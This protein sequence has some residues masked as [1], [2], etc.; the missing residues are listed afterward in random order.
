MPRLLRIVFG[1]ALI[2]YLGICAGLFLF[3]RSLI[4]FP[5]P[6]SGNN[7]ATIT[8]PAV[9]ARVLVSTRANNGLRA[10]IYFGWNAE[11][12]SFNMPSLAAAFP[13]H[14]IYL[15]HYRGSAGVPAAHPRRRSSQT[16]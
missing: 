8:L 4:Y 7:G 16:P 11:D 5:Q 12:V 13:D 14:A 2:T 15:L 10:L 1:T 9:D 6:D 3:Q